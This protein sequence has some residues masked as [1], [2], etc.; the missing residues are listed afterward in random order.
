MKGVK[1]F[2]TVAA[3]LLLWSQWEIGVQLFIIGNTV[4]R[5][6]HNTEKTEEIVSMTAWL[7]RK[8]CIFKCLHIKDAGQKQ[9]LIRVIWC[10]MKDYAR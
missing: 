1:S 4:S 10:H 8:E 7:G 3:F 9:D 2:V 5:R 6:E